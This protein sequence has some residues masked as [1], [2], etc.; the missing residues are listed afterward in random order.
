MKIISHI[1]NTI[2]CLNLL[3]GCVAVIMAFSAYTQFGPLMGWQWS[4]VFMGLA[5]VFDFLDG[6]AARLLK[7]YSK[8]GAELDSLSDLVSFGVAPAMLMYNIMAQFG[9]HSWLNYLTLAVPVFGALRL[10]RFNV[11]DAGSTSFRGL[12]IPSAAIFLIGVAGWVNSYGYPG[13]AVIVLLCLLASFAMVGRFYMFSL[14]FKNFAVH[15]NL[16]RYVLLAAA[17]VFMIIYGLSG[18]AWTILLYVLLSVM[19]R[20]RI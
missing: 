10:A 7:A 3:S 5:A 15:E 4:C 2:T 19:S 9:E 13:S 11:M 20:R 18:L 12:P 1:P 8:I 6:A 17:V 14:K 16:R